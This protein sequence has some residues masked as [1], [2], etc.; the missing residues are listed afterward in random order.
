MVVLPVELMFPVFLKL[1]PTKV[2]VVFLALIFPS[3][4]KS[5]IAVAE[6]WLFDSR[7]ALASLRIF[8]PLARLNPLVPV[9]VPESP[10]VMLPL[11]VAIS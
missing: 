6:I 11:A 10:L 8:P 5:P 9:I 4:R 2:R 3:F 7:E 1:S